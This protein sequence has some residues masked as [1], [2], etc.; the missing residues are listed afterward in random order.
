M[1][2]VRDAYL[3]GSGIRGVWD[4]QLA[5][6]AGS[7]QLPNRYGHLNDTEQTN[8]QTERPAGKLRC[9]RRRQGMVHLGTPTSRL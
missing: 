6:H 2:R 3:V 7:L 9:P 5:Y 8:E 1:S 4:A